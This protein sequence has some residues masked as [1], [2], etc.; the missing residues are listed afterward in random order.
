MIILA[1]M[2]EKGD[3]IGIP[4]PVYKRHYQIQSK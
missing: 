1:V 2:G 3:L 4:K